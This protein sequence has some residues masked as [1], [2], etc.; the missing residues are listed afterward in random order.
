MPQYSFNINDDLDKEFRAMVFK[1]K[2]M[3]R[4]ALLTAL[5]E[6]LDL[7]VKDGEKKSDKKHR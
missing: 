6:A 7:W 3:K 1:T 5:E 4:G 2:G